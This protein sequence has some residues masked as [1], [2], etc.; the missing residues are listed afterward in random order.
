MNLVLVKPQ[1]INVSNCVN[2]GTIKPQ[3]E[4]SNMITFSTEKTC[5][6]LLEPMQHK[7]NISSYILYWYG[8]ISLA[9]L[10]NMKR[11]HSSTLTS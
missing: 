5:N 6:I 2:E 9:K 8:L 4:K 11:K 1:H 10:T 7:D 3:M